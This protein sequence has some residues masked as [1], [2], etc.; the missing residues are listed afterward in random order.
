M[1]KPEK[2]SLT[3]AGHATSISLEKPFWAALREIAVQRQLTLPELVA[4]IDAQSREASLSSA[5][6]VYVLNRYRQN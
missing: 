3:I 4:E 5:I 1:D 2:R 6:R